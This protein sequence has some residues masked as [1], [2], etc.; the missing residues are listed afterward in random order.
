M[1]TTDWTKA[2]TFPAGDATAGE[3]ET[4]WVIP[5]KFFDELSVVMDEVPAR[6]GEEAL[7]AWIRSLLDAAPRDP[8]VA[9]VLRA[10]AIDANDTLV[11]DLF[12]FRNIGIPV[13]GNW[14]TERTGAASR[15]DY[16]SRT[17]MA[18]ANI[19]VNTPRETV[20]YYQDLD[21]AGERLNGANAYT[22]RF[23]AD[24]L[25][26]VKGFWSLTLYNEH[27]FFHPNELTRYSLG[28]K[29]KNLR[30][31]PDG[32]LTLYASNRPPS[33]DDDAANWLPAPDADFSLFIRAYWP[34]QAVLDGNWKPPSVTRTI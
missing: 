5:D 20:Y 18:K 32:S 7:Y 12:Q 22:I 31:G 24:G 11:A 23:P 6:P 21:E 29:N 4:Q 16:L 9:E 17:A 34:E 2:P 8:H 25:P 28:T 3:Q 15:T 1:Q 30:H 10:T 26:P 13:E 14:T 27:H 19:F 33:N